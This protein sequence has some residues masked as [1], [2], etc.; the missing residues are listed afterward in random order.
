MILLVKAVMVFL[1]GFISSFLFSFVVIPFLKRVGIR[2]SISEYVTRHRSKDKTP[3]M[4]G[5]IF[6]LPTLL[7]MMV[8]WR[9]NKVNI[10][11]NVLSVLVVFLGYALIGFMDDF[12]IVYRHNNN[13][14]SRKQKF[15]LQV[16]LAIIF[17]YLFI[18]AGNEPLLWIHSLN[19][20]LNINWFYG[21]FILFVLVASSNAV[22]LTDGLDGLS[23]GLSIM[24]LITFGIITY[25]T[26]WLEGYETIALMCFILSGCILGFLVFN[27]N[28]A[29]VFMGDTGSLCIGSFLGAVAIMTRH[30][31]LLILVGFVFVIE[32][33]SC[34]IQ[35]IYFKL[36]RKRLFLMTPLHH[37]F[38][39]KGY[40][41]KEI[42][43]GFW[44]VGML[45]S[46]L[47]LIYGVIL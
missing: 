17:F 3:T 44:I 38:E 30:E 45:S 2:Q 43:R 19:I 4:G 34:V 22:N 46:L 32:T 20:K 23:S 12:L 47:A 6:V 39:L 36:T 18:I 7:I 33:L 16:L 14:L 26:G 10:N 25:N 27:A 40:D 9:F 41:E 1:L 24:S 21:V 8:L 37:T 42:V 35:I 31:F 11:L 29:K 28:P 5:V 13:G 15:F